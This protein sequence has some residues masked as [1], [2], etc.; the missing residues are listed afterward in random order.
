MFFEMVAVYL[1]PILIAVFTVKCMKASFFAEGFFIRF[2]LISGG[3]SFIFISILILL[4]NTTYFFIYTVSY[5]ILFIIE[6]YKD[7]KAIA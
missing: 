2:V 4:F 7:S 6:L 5:L 1:L 3:F